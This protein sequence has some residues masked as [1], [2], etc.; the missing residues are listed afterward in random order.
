MSGI[1]TETFEP[2]Y[3]SFDATVVS[4]MAQGAQVLLPLDPETV[5][6][7]TEGDADPKFATFLIESGWS[8]QRNYWGA[9]V[10]ESVQEQINNASDP[11]VGYLGHIPPEQDGFAF[12]DI[13]LQWLKSKMQISSDKVKML[14]KAYVLP[15]T[16]G[17]DYLQRGLVRSVSWRGDCL[18]KPI[19][20]GVAI[21]D[22]V[23]ESIDLSRP[24]K[25]GMSAALVG[26][27]TSEM[28][29]GR[30][31][32]KPDEIGALTANELRAH[33]PTLVTAIE[34]EVKKPLEDKVTEMEAT[35]EEVKP[36]LDLIPEIRKLLGMAEDGD[37]L[38]VLGQ[39]M[40]QLKEAGRTAKDAILDKVLNRKFK[41][42]QTAK[43]V[44]RLIASEMDGIE[45]EGDE[46]KDEEAISSK[47]N[48]MVDNDAELKEMV[49]EMESGHEDDDQG[50]SVQSRDGERKP[51]KLEA[52]YS[53]ERIAVRAARR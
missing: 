12:P 1:A 31:D 5:A 28:D 26:G 44:K 8:K 51:R 15:D 20:G 4:E 34:D 52:G 48:E 16:R 35:A 45:L 17:R 6:R 22:F 49:S 23:L 50:R 47:V 33:N 39:T 24:R 9:E 14:V 43:L 38:E 2:I 10:F 7:V 3:D 11:I 13:Q 46:K 40:K 27:L 25:A 42:P 21:K 53:D 18:K 29:E 32:V 36:Q 41:D 30:K 37:I 19:A